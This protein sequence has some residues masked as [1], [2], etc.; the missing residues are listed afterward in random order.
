MSLFKYRIVIPELCTDGRVGL[1]K[2]FSARHPTL[3]FSQI[4]LLFPC[5]YFFETFLWPGITP[6]WILIS[7]N[8][9]RLLISRLLRYRYAC[10][11]GILHSNQRF[12][13]KSREKQAF[14]LIVHKAKL[15]L[16]F[17][18]ITCCLRSLLVLSQRVLM[19]NETFFTKSIRVIV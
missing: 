16:N 17:F 19:K 1:R 18:I 14:R 5:I 4:N 3:R 12:K 10:D 2:D 15:R 6:I 13:F 7:N 8:W 11:E 9:T